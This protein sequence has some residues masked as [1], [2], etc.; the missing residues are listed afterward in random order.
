MLVTCLAL[1]ILSISCA[2]SNAPR[3]WL[4]PPA[5]VPSSPLGA[6][7]E[8]LIV[9]ARAEGTKERKVRLWSEGEF[10]AVG[11]D[12]V[13]VL[14]ARGVESIPLSHVHHARVA[15]YQSQTGKGALVT[16]A[17]VLSTASNGVVL[18]LTAP[19]WIIAGSVTAGAVSREPLHD[20]PSKSWREVSIYARFPQGLPAD[21][22]AAGIRFDPRIQPRAGP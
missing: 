10:L 3:S 21:F 5:D 9:E 4:P 1:A 20:V 17:G 18:I 15:L 8:V 7:I 16:A 11:A 12:S 2:S 14:T 13:H 6:W 19:V 22:D